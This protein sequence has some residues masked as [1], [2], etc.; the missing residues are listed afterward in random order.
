M[1]TKKQDKNNASLTPHEEKILKMRG[2]QQTDIDEELELAS[3]DP[4]VQQRLLALEAAIFAK[5]R[6]C[7]KHA[8]CND[9]A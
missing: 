7:I 3:T 8:A 5:A 1:G 2:K 4:I 9:D 6:A